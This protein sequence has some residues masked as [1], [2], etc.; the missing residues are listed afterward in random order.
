M[1]SLI[2]GMGTYHC[3]SCSME[4]FGEKIR[5]GTKKSL[6]DILGPFYISFARF[7]DSFVLPLHPWLRHSGSTAGCSA[8]ILPAYFLWNLIATTEQSSTRCNWPRQ[9]RPDKGTDI[10]LFTFCRLCT[11]NPVKQ[12]PKDRLGVVIKFVPPLAIDAIR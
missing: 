11:H 5:V 9:V 4:T 1:N 2:R 3:P 12:E 7:S 8:K 10:L 6:K